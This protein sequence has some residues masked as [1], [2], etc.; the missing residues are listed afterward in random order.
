ME[1]KKGSA[2]TEPKEPVPTGR[3]MPHQVL[4]DEGP[5]VQ[6]ETKKS[7]EESQTPPEK[8]VFPVS[9]PAEIGEDIRRIEPTLEDET[10]PIVG[11]ESAGNHEGTRIEPTLEDEAVPIVGTESIPQPEGTPKEWREK[12]RGLIEGAKEKVSGVREKA[13][14][15]VKSYASSSEQLIWQLKE[16]DLKVEKIGGVE[17]MFRSL[18]E[19]YN[20]LGWKS[21][22]GIGVAL[23]LGAGISAPVNMAVAAGFL[24]G[25]AAQR[26]AGLA[27]MYLKFE[28]TELEKGS[29]RAK[30]KAFLKA[31]LYTAAMTAGTMY[32]V[33]KIAETD[34]YHRTQE[35]LGNML[36]HHPAPLAAT[37][38]RPSAVAPEASPVTVPASPIEAS[39]PAPVPV[40]APEAPA[41]SAQPAA[42]IAEA[43]P[44]APVTP[45]VAAAAEAA[46]PAAKVEIPTMEVSSRGY[47]YTLKQLVRG[48]P[49]GVDKS[50]FSPGSDMYRLL[51]ATDA[52]SLDKVVHDIATEKGLFDASKG[53]SSIIYKG[54]LIQVD[55]GTGRISIEGT[56][57]APIPAAAAE[58]ATPVPAKVE[59]PVPAQPAAATV[60]ENE[61]PTAPLEWDN[62]VLRS[63][64]GIV[65]TTSDGSPVPVRI[66]SIP[67]PG[68][69]VFGI[70]VSATTPRIY[71]GEGNK[72]LV[73][74]STPENQ[75]KAIGDFFASQENAKSVIYGTDSESKY[76]IPYFL[77]PDGKPTAGLPEQ[78]GWLLKSWAK[79]PSLDELQKID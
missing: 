62:S 43:G 64:D 3:D 14:E 28:K 76:R 12:L 49:E 51:D 19:K 57:K 4:P 26:I 24:S 74:G 25:I 13:K 5:L 63:S 32:A 15:T 21:K 53:E 55:Q 65:V 44:P 16:M 29:S 45:P 18:G 66:E 8:E 1:T 40:T 67:P 10:V 33:E 70:E 7:S 78:T 35:W 60:A 11:T 73:F 41:A 39:A 31:A 46:A 56:I 38:P 27:A 54:A 36:G 22:L 52:K 61:Q 50:A 47:E 20:K 34:I 37:A 71:A 9:Q 79:P 59:A 6:V 2:W 23:G 30:E 42:A 72:L 75:A 68:R 17:E 77:G 58:A 69:N 48:L